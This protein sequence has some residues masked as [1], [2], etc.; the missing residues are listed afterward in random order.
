[1]YTGRKR[2]EAEREGREEKWF[3]TFCERMHGE[4]RTHANVWLW[5]GYGLAWCVYRRAETT[6]GNGNA[7]G[8]E[9]E[10]AMTEVEAVDRPRWVELR[11]PISGICL[12]FNERWQTF[13]FTGQF[14]FRAGHN[15][16]QFVNRLVNLDGQQQRQKLVADRCEPTYRRSLRVRPNGRLSNWIKQS[17][18]LKSTAVLAYYR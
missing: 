7:M 9:R 11:R 4:F 12:T 8:R 17:V 2:G 18:P 16:R 1:M 3:T 13:W 14:D 5:P 15:N 10:G 6:G